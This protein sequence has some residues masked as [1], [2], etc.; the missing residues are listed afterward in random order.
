MFSI[1]GTKACIVAVPNPRRIW[2]GHNLDKEICLLKLI[3]GD[4]ESPPTGIAPSTEHV[5]SCLRHEKCR[6]GLDVV[7]SLLPGSV[8]SVSS[9]IKPFPTALSWSTADIEEYDV[10]RMML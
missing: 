8:P 1:L 5:L 10:K 2:K 9:N 3:C 4:A 7:L 6:P